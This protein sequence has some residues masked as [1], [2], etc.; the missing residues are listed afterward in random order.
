MIKFKLTKKETIILK[1]F[2]DC[3]PCVTECVCKDN[4]LKSCKECMNCDLEKFKA[5]ME[6]ILDN[7]TRTSIK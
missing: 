3:N 1:A 4:N 7:D 2:L 5:K 6:R